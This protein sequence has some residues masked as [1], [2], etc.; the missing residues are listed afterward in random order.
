ME[1]CEECGAVFENENKYQKHILTHG[2]MDDFTRKYPLV[3]D[4]GCDFANGGWTEQRSKKWF[5]S[6]LKDICKVIGPLK[7]DDKKPV[8]PMSYVWYRI[9]DDGNSPYYGLACRLLQ[10]CQKC[11]REH[12]QPYYAN[13]CTCDKKIKNTVVI[14]D[15]FFENGNRR[16]IRI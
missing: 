10:V 6:Y 8:Q 1:K 15:S 9:L 3:K 5:D 14:D 7:W 16:M 13:N 4:S 11:W 12:G 2:R